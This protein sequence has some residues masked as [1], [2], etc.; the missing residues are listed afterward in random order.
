MQLFNNISISIFI[1]KN[2]TQWKHQALPLPSASTDEFF[3]S[4]RAERDI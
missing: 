1:K 2:V 3:L 4:I